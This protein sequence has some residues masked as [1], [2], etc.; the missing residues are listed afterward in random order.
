MVTIVMVTIVIVTIVRTDL[1]MTN[2]VHIH[3]LERAEEVSVCHHSLGHA[4]RPFLVSLEDD[5]ALTHALHLWRWLGK[6]TNL[7]DI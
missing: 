4:P 2:A 7:S 5:D 1:P 3:V 6:G